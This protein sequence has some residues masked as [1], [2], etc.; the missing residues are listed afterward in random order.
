M[1]GKL[2]SLNVGRIRELEHNGVPVKTAIYKS[3]T[4]DPQRLANNYVGEDQQA[5]LKN[6]GGPHK[7][8]YAY[9]SEDYDWW[10]KNLDRELPPGTFGENLTTSGID[11]S[12]A[13]VGDRWN[14]GAAVLEVS[15]PRIPCFKLG[16][17]M[18]DGRFQQAFAKA[19]RPGAYLRIITE[20]E[21]CVEQTVECTPTSEPTI[22]V[23]EIA[24]IYNSDRDAAVSLLDV[25]KLSDAWVEWAQQT[26]DKRS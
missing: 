9:A 3:P 14:I 16:I 22:T 13:K 17:R 26:I 11:I 21:V 24:R 12:N 25:A 19:N 23:A 5:D 6:H 2:T 15:E 4:S 8:V 20:G 10:E 1:T 18:Q 7:A